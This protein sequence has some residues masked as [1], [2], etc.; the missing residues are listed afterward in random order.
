MS[1]R[2]E[3]LRERLALT[4]LD[5]HFARFLAALDGRGDEDVAL[6]ACL[7][8]QAT[9]SGHVCL[10]LREWTGEVAPSLGVGIPALARWIAALR[11]SRVVGRPGETRP[12]VLDEG[13]RL[14]LHR[15]WDYERTLALELARRAEPAEGVDEDRLRDDLDRLFPRRE[16][17]TDWQKVAAAV[18]VL[19]RL[20]VIS[21]GPGTGKTTTVVRILALLLAQRAGAARAPA[22]ALA[23]PTGKAAARMQDAV[24]AAKQSLELAPGIAQAI[25]EEAAT[26]HRLLG[27]R[28]GSSYFRHHRDNPLP[29]DVVV[30]DEASMV[31]QALMTKLVSAL[32]P[33][34]R[35]ILLG[36]KDQLASVE[37]GAVLADLCGG[38]VG[39]SPP[40]AAR[41]ERVTGE[42]IATAPTGPALRDSIVHLRRSYRFGR[43]S[44]I[45][46][47]AELVRTGEGDAALALLESGEC[48][49]LAWRPIESPEALARAAGTELAVRFSGYLAEVQAQHP[50]EDALAAFN[51]FRVLCAHRTGPSGAVTLNRL[52]EHGLRARRLADTRRPWY[53]GRPV[54]VGRNDY[55]LRLYNGD[56]G[57]AVRDA[58]GE[59]VVFAQP[60]HGVRRLAPS[61]LPEHETVYAM[62]VHKA[63][64]SEFDAVLLVLPGEVSRAVSRELIYTAITRARSRIEIWGAPAVFRAGVGR[65]VQRSSGLRD[66]LWKDG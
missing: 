61:R 10:D 12:L 47:L 35:L 7:V 23:A 22:L 15:Y 45:G 66:R 38:A 36:D 51:A 17:G 1:D 29:F 34:A 9:G 33:S 4:E 42:A 43:E 20:C 64:G 50:L 13:D 63:Q 65:R 18:A 40:F 52:I 24:R 37:S 16:P 56:V 57:I 21:G 31:D 44:G 19:R 53:P 49:D 32:P 28:P 25:P 14:Y 62:T 58:Q 39:C 11:A 8:S 2:L 48:P 46:R 54:M 55:N 26:L 3:S 41:I 60:D 6:A 27:A 30:V 59:S 5:L